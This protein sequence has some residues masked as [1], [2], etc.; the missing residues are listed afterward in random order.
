MGLVRGLLAASGHT[1]HLSEPR[2]R[3]PK[4]VR[5]TALCMLN[6]GVLV[7]LPWISK[8]LLGSRPPLLPQKQLSWDL[9]GAAMRACLWQQEIEP[10]PMQRNQTDH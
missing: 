1:P 2:C 10:S 5:A 6:L 3:L 9:P 4:K 7:L 8:S